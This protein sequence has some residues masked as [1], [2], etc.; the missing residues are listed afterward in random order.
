MQWLSTVRTR[1]GAIQHKRRYLFFGL[2]ALV[3]C[4]GLI[5]TYRPLPE[6]VDYTGEWR[7]LPEVYFLRDITYVDEAGEQGHDHQIMDTM[8]DMI[9]DADSLLVLDQF[10]F[11]DF[12]GAEG[13]IKR[14]LSNELTD[15]V[16]AR[17]AE[18]PD[19]SV[20]F[21][22]DPLNT[23]YGGVES[24]QQERLRE[25]G[26]PV[27]QTRLTALRDS[28]PAHSVWWRLFWRHYPLSW[29]P[30]LPN[31]IASGRVPLRSYL[32]LMNFKAN[33]R[34]TMVLDRDDE[35]W[36]MV[37]SANPHDASSAHDN[38]AVK[39]RGAAAAD[40]LE[41]ERAV[42]RFSGASIPAWEGGGAGD[43][44]S[45][46]RGDLRGR[47]VT[48]RAVERAALELL[49][50]AEPGDQVMLAM[51]YLSSRPIVRGLQQAQ[52]RGV[53]VRV[54]LDPNKDAFGREKNGVPN[55][56]VGVQLE[57]AGVSV[58]WAL[59]HGEQFHTK[60]LARLGADGKAV[61]IIGSSNYTRRNLKNFNLET[62]LEVRGPG[63]DPFFQDIQEYL[64]QIWTNADGRIVSTDFAAFADVPAWHHVLY[65]VQEVTGMS[66]F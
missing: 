22:T 35:L 11:N 41:T 6:H 61:A 42:A 57:R 58:R 15:A 51:F 8:F 54:L 64:S 40:L 56:P 18:N 44:S 62:C 34:K 10:L 60:M 4:T 27:I 23:L 39:F 52:S 36:G 47:I 13:N 14:P 7:D 16:L 17:H 50:T 29:G 30:Q 49:D 63:T 24:P 65:W 46:E 9:A 20:W 28:N 12:A 5:M 38:V 21:I 53:K 19:L 45:S 25:H 37:G 33:H 1:L 3:V 31:P 32:D 55:R 48:E 26:I 43:V 2:V 59:T 66:T